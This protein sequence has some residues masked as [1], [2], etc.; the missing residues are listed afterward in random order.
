MRRL[1]RGYIEQAQRQIAEGATAKD[2]KTG[3]RGRSMVPS[4]PKI[5]AN[6]RPRKPRC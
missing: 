4:G 1:T 5:A 6:L 2:Q 3:W